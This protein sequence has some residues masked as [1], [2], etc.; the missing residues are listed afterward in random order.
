MG[1]GAKQLSLSGR[2][3]VSV[4]PSGVE[5]IQDRVAELN[6][7]K[8]C[9]RTDNGKEVTIMDVGFSCLRVAYPF[10]S[11]TLHGRRWHRCPCLY[12]HLCVKAAKN[13]DV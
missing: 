6:P 3:T 4:I 8:N 12:L 5:W 10:S 11:C 9:I 13:G 1:A 7:D 2:P